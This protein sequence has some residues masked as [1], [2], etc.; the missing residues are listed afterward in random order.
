M[1]RPSVLR[2][3]EAQSLECDTRVRS[4]GGAAIDGCLKSRRRTPAG[5][6]RQG[7]FP[8]A[9]DVLRARNEET[10]ISEFRSLVFEKFRTNFREDIQPKKGLKGDKVMKKNNQ[11]GHN[12]VH[13]FRQEL[14][15]E[16][17]CESP[18]QI[19]KDYI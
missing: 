12:S 8:S 6:S 4:G 10:E 15:I 17:E 16:Q 14:S 9:S 18:Y 13:L 7:T 1:M 19:R 11:V 3:A 2:R 5:H